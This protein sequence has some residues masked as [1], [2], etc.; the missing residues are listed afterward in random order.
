MT[1]NNKKPKERTKTVPESATVIRQAK[2]IAEAV[3][4]VQDRAMLDYPHAYGW[5]NEAS[6]CACGLDSKSTLNELLEAA[7]G[8]RIASEKLQEMGENDPARELEELAQELE[9]RAALVRGV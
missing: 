3:E 1:R 8:I 7:N 6:A 4:G 2:D 5:C 9:N